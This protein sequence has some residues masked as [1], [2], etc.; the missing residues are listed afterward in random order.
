MPEVN[1]ITMPVLL[2]VGDRDDSTPPEHQK[3]LFDAL[4]GKKEMHVIKGA[5]HTFRDP[6]HLEKIRVIFDKWIKTNL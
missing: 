5:P 3:I 4:T 1:K 6:V 2:I